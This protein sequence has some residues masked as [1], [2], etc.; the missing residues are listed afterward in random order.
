LLLA[1]LRLL[2]LRLLLLLLRRLMLLQLRLLLLQLLL[3]LLLLLLLLCVPH[4]R[5]LG[6]P[7]LGRGGGVC[8]PSP[9]PVRRRWGDSDA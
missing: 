8:L 2:L 7:P 6:R 4:G 9:L 5:G 1:L 3:R